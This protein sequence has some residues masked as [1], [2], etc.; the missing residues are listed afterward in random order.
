MR[1]K[2]YCA[3]NAPATSEAQSAEPARKRIQEI[4]KTRKSYVQNRRRQKK[5]ENRVVV[6]GNH[7]HRGVILGRRWLVVKLR[8]DTSPEGEVY[9]DDRQKMMV[10]GGSVVEFVKS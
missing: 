2:K 8:I 3:K 9:I 5:R 7:Y 4:I 6:I 1:N 10:D